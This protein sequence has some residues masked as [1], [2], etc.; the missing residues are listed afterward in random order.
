MKEGW[1]EEKITKISSIGGYQKPE[2]IQDSLKLDSNENYVISKQFQNGPRRHS[3]L[4]KKSCHL[5]T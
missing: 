1:F 2:L 4:S 5:A 3:E